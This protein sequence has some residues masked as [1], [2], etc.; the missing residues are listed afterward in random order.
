M[1]YRCDRVRAKVGPF[2]DFPGQVIAIDANKIT[3][4]L[5]IFGRRPTPVEYQPDQL[6]KPPPS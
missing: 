5:D 2:D 4:N 6:D 3:S 1:S